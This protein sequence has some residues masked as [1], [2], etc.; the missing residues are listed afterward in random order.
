MQSM[1]NWFYWAINWGALSSIITTNIEKYHSF[2]LAY[3]LPATVFVGAIVILIFGRNRLIRKAPNGSLVLRAFQLT[4]RAIR[5]RWKLGRQDNCQHILD[6]AKENLSSTAHNS[7]ETVD[8]LNNN[9]FIE[10]LKQAW[11]ACRVFSVY[12]FYWICYNQLVGN[13]ISQAAQMNVGKYMITMSNS[14]TI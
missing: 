9:Q 5:M 4:T 10:D 12:P 1:F 7:I 8:G 2:S 13:L 14:L 11:S 3:L 6:Y